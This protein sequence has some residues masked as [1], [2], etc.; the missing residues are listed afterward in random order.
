MIRNILR[1]TD[2]VLAISQGGY[3]FILV[4]NF[5]YFVAKCSDDKLDFS[6]QKHSCPSK[7]LSNPH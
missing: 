6:C 4:F 1:I 5:G 2:N 3:K 7:A